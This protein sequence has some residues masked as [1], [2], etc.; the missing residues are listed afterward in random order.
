LTIVQPEKWGDILPEL[1]ELFPFHWQ[2]IALFKDKI[3]MDIDEPRYAKLEEMGALQ[4]IT[5]RDGKKLI[6]YFVAFVLPHMHYK[7][8]L[9]ASTDMY[10]ILPEYRNGTGAKMFIEM[11]RVLKERGVKK[12]VTSCKVEHDHT[13]LLEKLGWQWTDKTFCKYLGDKESCH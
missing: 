4:V 9:M 7:S 6:G 11:E 10:F 8:T 5:A 12:A 1:R 13:A 3:Q 2:E